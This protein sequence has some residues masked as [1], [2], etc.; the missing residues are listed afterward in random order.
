TTVSPAPCR[1][2][3]HRSRRI[4]RWCARTRSR[5]RPIRRT[6]RRGTPRPAKH[7][8]TYPA[9]RFSPMISIPK[10]LAAIIG[11]MLMHAASAA[12]PT[13]ERTTLLA[14]YQSTNGD[15]WTHNDNWNGAPG[16]ECTWYGISCI[17]DHVV[18]VNLYNNNAT[19]TLPPL[20][21][22]A[23]LMALQLA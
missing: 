13:S 5:W 15:Q 6:T 4:F 16:T 21:A 23:Q 19:G 18:S 17:G 12:I 1:P 14:L 10:P 20:G 3:R 9:T 8:G 11:A 22:L 2:R 7:R